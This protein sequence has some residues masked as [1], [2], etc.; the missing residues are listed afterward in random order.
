MADLAERFSFG[1]LRTTHEQ[2]MV[3]ADVAMADLPA[4]WHALRR[5]AWGARTPA[6]H[7]DMICCPGGDYCSLANAKS[8]PV[9]QANCR[10]ASRHLTTS[11][12]S[13]PWS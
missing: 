13:A 5:G 2:N 4:L 11:T 7:G 3:L 8:I 1:E 6:T 12:I 10:S 9:A